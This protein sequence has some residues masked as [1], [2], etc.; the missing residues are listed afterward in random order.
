MKVKLHRP[1]RGLWNAALLLLVVGLLGT[2]L[3]IPIL[4]QVA[5]YL[6]VASAVLMLLGTWIV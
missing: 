1:R 4:S 3:P 6:V 5:F 2:C